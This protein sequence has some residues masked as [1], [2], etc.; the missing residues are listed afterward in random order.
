MPDFKF[1]C[2][3]CGQ[4]MQCDE[5]FAGKQIKC[6]ACEHLILIP[7]PP[8]AAP[9][10]YK[11]ESGKTWATFVGSPVVPRPGKLSI[12]PPEEPPADGGK[13]N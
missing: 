4:R 2:S 5:K 8:N 12:R 6:P 10:Q 7:A 11:P 1:D 9:E 13:K 3:H